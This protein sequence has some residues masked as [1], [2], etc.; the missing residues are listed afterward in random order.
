[1]E[2]KINTI[3]SVLLPTLFLFACT[4][5]DNTEQFLQL[6]EKAPSEPE[7]I[8]EIIQHPKGMLADMTYEQD[9]DEIMEVIKTHMPPIKKEVDAEYLED[10]WRAY[11]SLFAE[12]YP[13]PSP[14][15]TEKTFEP[16]HHPGI[17]EERYI[18]KEQINVLVLLDVSGSMGTEVDGKPMIDIAKSSIQEFISQ[19]PEDANVGLRVYGHEGAKTGATVEESCRSTELVYRIQ[20]FE[21]E[22]FRSELERY[23]PVGYTPLALSLEEAREDFKE[24]PGEANTNLIYVV[25]DGLETCG[26]DPVATAEFLSNSNIQPI[27]NVIGFNV[28]NQSQVQLQEISEAGKGTYTSAGDEEELNEVFHQAEEIFRLWKN[29]QS[30]TKEEAAS[31]RDEQYKLVNEF[32]DKWREANDNERINIFYAINELRSSGYITDE[33]HSFFATKRSDRFEHYSLLKENQSTDLIEKINKNYLEIIEE[34]DESFKQNTGRGSKQI[35]D[36]YSLEVR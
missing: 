36:E 17:E 23:Q 20:P 34:V 11:H 31:H 28:D 3:L 13:D 2:K 16:F 25:S 15:F 9:M 1:M 10:W 14:I 35:E 4:S 12:D 19:L 24:Y 30:R 8:D 27:I 29:W 7:T 33:A 22:V 5:N 21:K 18:F 26:K 32:N 6:L